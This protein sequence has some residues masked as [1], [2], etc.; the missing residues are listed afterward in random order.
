MPLTPTSLLIKG[1][2][3]NKPGRTSRLSPGERGEIRT[4]NV[5]LKRRALC[6]LSYA[7]GVTS[8][9]A[10]TSF[11]SIQAIANPSFLNTQYRR[12]PADGSSS[13]LAEVASRTIFSL[14]HSPL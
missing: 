14:L 9:T 10:M 5:S 11:A 3:S 7:L 4:P 13:I 2:P 12:R 1:A 6:Q 8:M